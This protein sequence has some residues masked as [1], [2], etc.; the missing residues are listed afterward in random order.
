MLSFV[1]VGYPPAP[2]PVV[3]SPCPQQHP[4]LDYRAPFGFRASAS[5][6]FIVTIIIVFVLGRGASGAS[7]GLS[8]MV[9]VAFEVSWGDFSTVNEVELS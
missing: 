7:S 8:D 2:A 6:L 4:S 5:H 3:V 9:G 1:W